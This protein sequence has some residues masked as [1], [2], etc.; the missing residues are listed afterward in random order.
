M[1]RITKNIMDLG[2]TN[3]VPAEGAEV[4][5]WIKKASKKRTMIVEREINGK[6]K[7]IQE[8]WEGNIISGTGL[9]PQHLPD[10]RLCKRLK[11]L[12]SEWYE[13]SNEYN[14]NFDPMG[15]YTKGVFVNTID[16][17]VERL[18]ALKPT[19]FIGGGAAF[20]DQFLMAAA[21]KLGIPT[22]LAAPITTQMRT[23]PDHIRKIYIE[24]AKKAD[25]VVIVTPDEEIQDANGEVDK[26]LVV[27]AM[28]KRNRYMLKHAHSVISIWRGTGGGTR[29]CVRDAL[30]MGLKVTDVYDDLM[31]K[32]GYD[33]VLSDKEIPTFADHASWCINE[34]YRHASFLGH[35]KDS[36]LSGYPLLAVRA[37]KYIAA[38]FIHGVN[39]FDGQAEY[40][41]FLRTLHT[42]E[43]PTSTL[44]EEFDIGVAAD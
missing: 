3:I 40:R 4:Q 14:R 33:G 10:R 38:A 30:K 36:N 13:E 8:T 16:F 31:A 6:I 34:T 32:V 20:G 19:G 2:L 27:Y 37:W 17:F 7:K 9:R 5:A 12:P 11:P 24:Q 25:V 23:F 1:T 28:D 35:V 18:K 21:Q 29:N 26:D 41:E 22:L 39:T 42:K 43:E 15:S 44:E